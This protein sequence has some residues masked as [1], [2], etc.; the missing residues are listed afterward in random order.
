MR[1]WNKDPDPRRSYSEGQVFYIES[2]VPP[3]DVQ[4][5]IEAAERNQ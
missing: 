3:K 2:V 4:A 1:Y 5:I